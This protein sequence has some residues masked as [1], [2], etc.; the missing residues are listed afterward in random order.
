MPLNPGQLTISNSPARFKVVIAGRRWGKTHLATREL[1]HVCRYP[2]K[3][4]WYI[5]PSYRM[6]RN[7]LWDPLKT[8]LSTLNWIAKTNETDLSI[9]LKNGS[10]IALKGADNPDSLRGVSLDAVVFDEFAWI[11][12]TAWTHVIRPTLSDRQG[13][14]M[15][16]S[17]PI[18]RNWAY[19]LYQRGLDPTEHSWESFSYT[20]IEGGNVTADEIESARRD[21]DARTFRQ[22]YEA[23]FEDYANRIFYSFDR[24]HNVKPYDKSTPK[25]I[26]VGLDFNVGKMS[27]A[28]FAQEGNNVHAIDEVSM[29]SSNT[30]E[31]CDEIISRYPGTK[32]F[33]YPDPSG[34]ARKSSAASGTTD[35]TILANAGFVVKAPHKHNPVRDG[36]NAVNSKLCSA[37]NER[38]LYIDPRCKGI[39]E[40]LEKH[41]YKE[42]SS[43]PDKDSGFD[44]MSDAI[45]YYIDYVFPVRR[46]M[47]PDATRPQRWGHGIS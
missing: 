13:T 10:K 26:H 43:Q 22:E 17:T 6:C 40:S 39:I 25:V 16:I 45:R 8:R 7:I 31:V 4:A 36:I 38:T 12:E 11:D 35:H 9:I 2:N 41:S 28:I 5:A 3:L 33:V 24:A 27:A 14:A 34:A 19:D 23:T 21:L 44:H 29:Q 30:Q 18:G 20:T 46:D 42:G 37:S 47:D 32:V 1:A 15:F